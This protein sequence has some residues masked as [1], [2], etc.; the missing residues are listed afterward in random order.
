MKNTGGALSFDATINDAD[1]KKTINSMINDMQ[2]LSS[3]AQK[4]ASS[5]DRAFSSGLN[6]AQNTSKRVSTSIVSDTNAINSSFNS[7][8]RTAAAAFA[9][10]QLAQLPGQIVKVRG[11]FQQLEIA[12]TTMLQSSERGGKLM[13]EIIQTAATTPFSMQSLATGAKQMIAFGSQAENVVGEL[14]MLGD[15]AAGLSIPLGDLVYVYG[16]LRT[17]QRAYAIDM[18]QFALR[19]IP[20]YEEV[21]KVMGVTTAEVMDLVS[22]GKVGFAEVEKAFQ[23][24]TAAGSM[25]GGLMDAQSKSIPGLIERLKDSIAI[26]YNE[27]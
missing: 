18:R 8:A 15:V 21:A 6:N 9:G 22:A 14:R 19:G 10:L 26:M 5:L 27:I 12:L 3:S 25:F 1:F 11:E 24:M 20:I 7:L 2:R 4:G 16:T 17:Q 13:Q 23:N